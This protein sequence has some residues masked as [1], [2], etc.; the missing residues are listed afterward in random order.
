MHIRRAGNLSSVMF[1]ATFALAAT[2][3]LPSQAKSG[4][5]V[6]LPALQA[7]LSQ[8]SV[9]GLSSG[10]FMAAQFSVAYSG[11]VIGAGIVAGGPYYCSG[12]PGIYPFIPYVT[13]AVST[14]MNPAKAFVAPPVA[15]VLWNAAQDFARSGVIDDTANVKKQRIYL[16]SGTEDSTVTQAVVDQ[17]QQFYQLAGVA[18]AQIRYVNNVAAGH[19]FITDKNS[20]Q[21]C[22]TTASPY[23]NDCDFE[24]SDDILRHIY[25][26]LNPPVSTLGGSMLSFNQR[27]FLHT[28]YSS[29]SNTAYVYVPKACNTESCR[30]HVVFH[31]CGQGATAIGDRYYKGTGYN[32]IADSNKIIV[33]YPQVDASP[34][35][36]YNPKGCWDFWGYTSIN[37]FMPDFYQKS[38]PQ[39]S[40][41]KAM[42]D[43]LAAPRGSASH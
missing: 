30:V 4:D 39:M 10:A 11:T 14:C 37:P 38:A 28:P 12:S 15:S 41:V 3:S 6:A 18:P 23:I 20:D 2:V 21:S 7:D 5:P 13:N 25:P 36:P 24:Q 26:N 32:E 8:T 17:T 19:A 43:R 35:Y 9:S 22:P 40:A 33:L 42:L 1:L 27:S 16:F 31:G 29:M 34:V